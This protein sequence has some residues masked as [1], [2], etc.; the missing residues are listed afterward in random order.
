MR[1]P[2]KRSSPS[3]TRRAWGTD[4]R[5]LAAASTGTRTQQACDDDVSAA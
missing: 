5:Q 3:P 2:K 1:K 4:S